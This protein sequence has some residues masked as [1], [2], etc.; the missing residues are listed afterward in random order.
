MVQS[1]TVKAMRGAKEEEGCVNAICVDFFIPF[2]RL[3]I[4]GLMCAFVF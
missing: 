2:I 4:T 1:F 3:K